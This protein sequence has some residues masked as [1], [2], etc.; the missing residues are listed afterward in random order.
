MGKSIYWKNPPGSGLADRMT[1]MLF[2]SAYAR[3]K[4]AEMHAVWPAFPASAL[5]VAHRSVDILLENVSQFI[6]FPGNIIFD[7]KTQCGEIFL[8]E[9]CPSS[10]PEHF[11]SVYLREFCDASRYAEAYKAAKKEFNFCSEIRAFLETLPERFISL[12]IRRGDKVRNGQHDGFFIRNDE[13]EQVDRLTHMAIDFY[14]DKGCDSFFVCGDEDAKNAPFVDYIRAKNCRL[15][16]IP[17]MEK[18]K[19]TYYDLAVMTRSFMNIASQRYSSFSKFPATIGRG[20]WRTVFGF[21]P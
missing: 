3:V 17:E 9:P 16:R 8:N 14:T 2:M 19:S 5:D 11:H 7:G 21:T 15:V 12:H 18:W 13:L 1:V 6:N 10:Q 20:N 4:E